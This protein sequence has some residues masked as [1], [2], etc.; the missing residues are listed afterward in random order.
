MYGLSVV[1]FWCVTSFGW[2]WFINNIMACD[3][4]SIMKIVYPS[5]VFYISYIGCS[6]IDS[7]FVS[8]GKTHYNMVNSAI[9][10]IGYYGIVYILFKNGIFEQNLNFI[11]GMF[12]FG[13]VVH[14][15]VSVVCYTYDTKKKAASN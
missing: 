10:N 5:V 3:P 4:D 1:A 12:G 11:I 2:P 7:W 6:F 9:V 15:L 14:L 8:K 13:M